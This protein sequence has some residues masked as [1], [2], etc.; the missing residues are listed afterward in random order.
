MTSVPTPSLGKRLAAEALGS[1][2]L[3]CAVIGSGI[4][5]E[6]LAAGNAGVALIGNTLATVTLLGVLIYTL[7]PISGAH[8]N[9]VVSLVMC[10]RR[11]LSARDFVAYTLTQIL[12]MLIG[13]M[14]AHAMFGLALV[15]TSGHV[16]ST[17]GEGIGECVATFVLLFTLLGTVRRNADHAALI[18]PAA[19]AAGYWFTSSTSFANPA[20]TIARSITDSFSGIAP[21]SIG[22]FVVA[23]IVGAGLA[24]WV[25]STLW[26]CPKSD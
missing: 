23:Q 18:V 12:A 17:V 5:A 20:I 16:R 3:A 9:P 8:F 21:D 26:R 25:A 19:I 14:L 24:T 11:A 10:L 1:L 4:M 6:R 7:S 22:L 15:Q 13:A 2:L